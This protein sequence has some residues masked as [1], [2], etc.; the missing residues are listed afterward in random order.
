MS[1]AAADPARQ[2]DGDALRDRL[3]AELARLHAQATDPAARANLEDMQRRLDEGAPIFLAGDPPWAAV[4]PEERVRR[5]AA[6]RA[7]VEAA[8]RGELATLGWQP[9]GEAVDEE[10]RRRGRR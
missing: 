5:E 8:G 3:R 9:A 7:A 10:L 1:A 6:R 4:T 2:V